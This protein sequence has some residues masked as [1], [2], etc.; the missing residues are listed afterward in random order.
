MLHELFYG[1]SISGLG[2]AATAPDMAEFF[3]SPAHTHTTLASSHNPS[4]PGE[5]VTL[6]AHVTVVAP[7]T[8]TPT[9]DVIFYNGSTALDT[10]AVGSNGE[11]TFATASLPVG[12]TVSPPVIVAM[13][14]SSKV[15][16]QHWYKRF[17]TQQP[18]AQQ[19]L[20][21]RP[22]TANHLL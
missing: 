19:F 11:A 16:R 6:T 20:R 21:T 22:F 15:Y 14:I 1:A 2:H 17:A 10:V 5:S 4:T 3:A 12:S 9:G 18:P 13:P 7:G 8:G